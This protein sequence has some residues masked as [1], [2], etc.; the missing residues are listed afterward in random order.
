M[1]GET[2]RVARLD[3][4]FGFQDRRGC[5]KF[6]CTESVEVIQIS[7]PEVIYR[8]IEEFILVKKKSSII[9][10]NFRRSA[11]RVENVHFPFLRNRISLESCCSNA[12][13]IL[14][15]SY[16]Q[17]PLLPS[18][19]MLV[20]FQRSGRKVPAPERRRENGKA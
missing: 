18:G 1:R 12:R 16:K 6:K 17:H 7:E 10:W 11:F 4:S 20:N 9:S 15:L 14:I 8:M 19:N 3:A 5:L 13:I 2:L